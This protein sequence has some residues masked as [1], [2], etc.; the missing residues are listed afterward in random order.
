MREDIRTK[1]KSQIDA[2]T[3]AVWGARAVAAVELYRASSATAWLIQ[4]AEYAAE[5]HEHAAGGPPGTLERIK[6]E[7]SALTGGLL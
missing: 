4:A 1:A 5:A 3:A 6:T 7:L 2:E